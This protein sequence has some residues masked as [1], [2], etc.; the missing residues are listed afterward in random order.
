VAPAAPGKVRLL[1]KGW[2]NLTVDG[3][4]LGQFPAP[5]RFP[6]N[7]VELPAGTHLVELANGPAQK[8]WRSVVKVEPGA[9][10][11]L[12]VTW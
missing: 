1:V 2:G 5:A 11:E 8:T 3:T 9:T 6:L 4:L 10:T 7:A 12:N